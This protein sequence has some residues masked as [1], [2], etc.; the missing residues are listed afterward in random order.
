MPELLRSPI[1][2][3]NARLAVKVTALDC[4][5]QQ[6][7]HFGESRSRSRR[8]RRSR[9]SVRVARPVA[10]FR[11]NSVQRVD[12]AA[13]QGVSVLDLAKGNRVLVGAFHADV[14]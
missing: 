1:S 6:V 8:R 14:V 4:V 11:G 12:H 9:T 3:T 7:S 13:A 2:Q 5:E 10:V